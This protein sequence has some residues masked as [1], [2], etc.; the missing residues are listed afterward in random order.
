MTVWR[1][2]ARQESITLQFAEL[3]HDDHGR[4]LARNLQGG[5]D[6]QTWYSDHIRFEYV[7]VIAIHAT[8]TVEVHSWWT[9][10]RTHVVASLTGSCRI[11]ILLE[12]LVQLH[13]V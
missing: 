2:G 11:E 3:T 10:T 6:H 5:A 4:V 8:G 1:R 12:V 13:V 7:F 9:L